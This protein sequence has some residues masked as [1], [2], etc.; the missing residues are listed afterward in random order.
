[1]EIV[2]VSP[3]MLDEDLEVLA[4][5]IQRRHGTETGWQDVTASL[6]NRITLQGLLTRSEWQYR[7]IAVDELE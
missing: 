4:Y 6:A 7:I 3:D 2:F 1:M 5:K